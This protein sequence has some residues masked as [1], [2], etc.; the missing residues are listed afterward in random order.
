MEKEKIQETLDECKEVFKQNTLKTSKIR[1]A[2]SYNACVTKDDVLVLQSIMQNEIDYLM[3]LKM[4]VE[5]ENWQICRNKLDCNSPLAIDANKM[6]VNRKN[7]EHLKICIGYVPHLNF[8]EYP[9]LLHLVALHQKLVIGSVANFHYGVYRFGDEFI[10]LC[11]E[12]YVD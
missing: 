9:K 6:F 1:H 10:K 11:D 3:R 8:A 4:L 2:I 7:A 5:K 12:L